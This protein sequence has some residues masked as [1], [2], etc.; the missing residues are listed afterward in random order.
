MKYVA[1]GDNIAYI[2]IRKEAPLLESIRY[3]IRGKPDYIIEK[4]GEYIP[5]EKRQAELP[6]V[7]FFP[8]RAAHCL[9]HAR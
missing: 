6:K 8:Y 9:L 5:V 4:D 3:G 1:S 2:G 7:L